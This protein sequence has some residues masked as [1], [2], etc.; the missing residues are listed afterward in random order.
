MTT[1]VHQLHDGPYGRTLEWEYIIDVDHWGEPCG[2]QLYVEGVCVDGDVDRDE[3]MR[4]WKAHQ[5]S[6]DDARAESTILERR[7]A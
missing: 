1:S 5:R 3:Y 4:V 7:A 6:Q 2:A